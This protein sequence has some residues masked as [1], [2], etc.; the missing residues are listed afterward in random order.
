M[1]IKSTPVRNLEAIRDYIK[2]VP[3]GTVRVALRAIVEYVIGDNTHGLKHDQPYKYASRAKAYGNTGARF[4]NGNPV[5][6]GYFS[7]AQF[8][9]VAAITKGFTQ[10]GRKNSPTNASGGYAYRETKGGYG[11]TI[12]NKEQ[13][14]YWTRDDKGQARQLGLMGWLKKSAVIASNMAGALRAGQAAVNKW[15]KG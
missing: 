8:R 13:S 6:A 4:A 14:A 2:T 3:R 9:K 15:L 11:A 12:E 10:F 1:R 5:P 7:A